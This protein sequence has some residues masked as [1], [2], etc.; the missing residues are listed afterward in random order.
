MALSKET[1]DDYV[2]KQIRAMMNYLGENEIAKPTL[3]IGEPGDVTSLNV[4]LNGDS[5]NLVTDPKTNIYFGG[6]DNFF[7]VNGK[8]TESGVAV[9]VIGAYAPYTCSKFID[10]KQVMELPP[11]ALASMFCGRLDIRTCKLMSKE[12]L[13]K[14][15]TGSKFR[16]DRRNFVKNIAPLVEQSSCIS[17]DTFGNI[18]IANESPLNMDLALQVINITKNIRPH[19]NIWIAERALGTKLEDNE[20]AAEK[21]EIIKRETGENAMYSCDGRAKVY[22]LI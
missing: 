17:W 2:L 14:L 21:L 8:P 3:T 13:E 16:N 10:G 9:D 15:R 11:F 7:N 6:W 1:Y 20:L 18:V 12:E 22:T 4:K 19:I 5:I